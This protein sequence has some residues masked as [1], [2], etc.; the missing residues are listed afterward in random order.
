MARC[1][2]PAIILFG[3]VTGTVSAHI[4][5]CFSKDSCYGV[6]GDECINLA[7]A[8]DTLT[9]RSTVRCCIDLQRADLSK[10]G[11]PLKFRGLKVLEASIK[12][13]S[14]LGLSKAKEVVLTGFNQG[15]ATAFYRHL[16]GWFKFVYDCCRQVAK[17]CSITLTESV[18]C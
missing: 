15:E 13:L 6:H 16:F 14:S 3:W 1:Y 11:I 5:K 10:N 7:I 17:R 18:G 12:L 2:R 4:L 9:S 8:L